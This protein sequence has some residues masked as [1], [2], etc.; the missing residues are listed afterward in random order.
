MNDGALYGQFRSSQWN[1]ADRGGVLVGDFAQLAN[2]GWA[3]G[4]IG[5]GGNSRAIHVMA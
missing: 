5:I 1:D 3:S 2:G 4:T